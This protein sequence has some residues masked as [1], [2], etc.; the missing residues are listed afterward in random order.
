M[1][2]LKRG[3]GER[4]LIGTNIWIVVMETCRGWARIGI[5]APKAVPVEREENLEPNRQ[6]INRHRRPEPE[7][8]D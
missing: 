4:I 5:E 6:F 7:G 8:A 3:V 2:V 1:L